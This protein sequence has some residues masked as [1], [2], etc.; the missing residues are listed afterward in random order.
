MRF[1]QSQRLSISVAGCLIGAFTLAGCHSIHSR[2]MP[3]ITPE[4]QVSQAEVLP[5]KNEPSEAETGPS[6]QPIPSYKLSNGLEVFLIEKKSI[7][8]ATVLIAVKNGSFA[9]NESNNGLAHLYEHM[10]FKANEKI[11]SQPEFL[12]TLD[13]MGIEL[14]PNMN[15]YT[16]TESVRYFFTLQ[17]EYLTRGLEFMADALITPKFVQEELEKERKVVIGEFD[18]Y[19]ASPTDVF[20]QRGVFSRLFKD[21]YI[22]KNVIGTRPVILS[23]TQEQMHEIQHRYYIPNNTALF[24][25]GDFNESE[26]KG[27][28]EKYFGNWKPSDDPFKKY[29]IPEQTPV[30]KTISFIDH[31]PVQSVNL[32]AAYQGPSLTKQD[33][34]TIA[35]DLIAMM[36][37]L[38]SS[39]FQKELVQSGIASHASFF[40]W[41]Q[42]YT[43]PLIFNLECT[44]EKAQKAYEVMLSL[45]NRMMKGG[46]FSEADLKTAKTSI[47][48]SSA[49]D[50][51]SGQ[52]FALSLASIWTSTGALNYY[53]QYIEE[54]KKITMADID[55][56]LSE[57]FNANYVM[58][59]L[60]PQGVNSLKF[61]EPAD[62]SVAAEKK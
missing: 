14:G 24:I 59:A 47:E 36:T 41:T 35:F 28:I 58:A 37:G 33:Q 39:P 22:R 51:E 27:A 29:P 8:M 21:H 43:S 25:V 30:K 16:S 61:Q 55:R 57:Y 45:K 7:P 3:E 6:M 5:L 19:E 44:P 42:R 60:L 1:L 49:Y 9:E 15:A 56:Y 2:A 50:R 11:T 53:L 31:A 13:E 17:S 48:V 46:F 52:K 40:S 34:A 38:E 32:V 54:M 20:F 18:R 12:R 23:A 26:T 62:D 10:F 4:N